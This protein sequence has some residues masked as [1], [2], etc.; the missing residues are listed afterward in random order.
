MRRRRVQ[1]GRLEMEFAPGGRRRRKRILGPGDA[2]RIRPGDHHRMTALTTCE[3]LEAS[4]PEVEDV[5]RLED[6]YG[7]VP[8]NG[9]ARPARSGKRK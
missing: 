1:R 2:L 9:A 7:R 5:V 6:R 4:S 3:L 8:Q